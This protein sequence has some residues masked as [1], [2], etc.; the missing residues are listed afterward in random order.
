[1]QPGRIILQS[2]MDGAFNMAADEHLLTK[3]VRENQII[4]RLFQWDPW[5][6]S[7]GKH[8]SLEE[9]DLKKC[10]EQR[11]MVVRRLTGGRAVLHARELTYSI[12]M[13]LANDA[14]GYHH[15]L[16]LT[17]GQ[18]LCYGLQSLGADVEWVPKGRSV[19][20]KHSELCF[21]TVARGEIL[22]RGKKVV[23]S[24]QRV[25]DNAVL[26][27][28]SILLDDGH[29]KITELWINSNRSYRQLLTTH[30]ATLHQ[31]LG[32]IPEIQSVIKAIT[33]GFKTY[34]PELVREE[35]LSHEEELA[36]RKSCD[37]FFL[38]GWKSENADMPVGAHQLTT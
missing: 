1:M 7:L 12:V 37:A 22:W 17:V 32:H 9:V 34:F 28:G 14:S 29:E 4:L 8:Q 25:L 5:S 35:E 16:A 36:I 26:Q 15:Q 6:L 3:A 2:P 18:A 13:P 38:G 23:G 11:I 31:I 10:S 27:H 19:T 24:A 20:G 30:T 21:T 33:E